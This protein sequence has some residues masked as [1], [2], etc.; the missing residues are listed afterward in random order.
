MFRLAWLSILLVV[1]VSPARGEALTYAQVLQRVVDRDAS[2]QIARMELER[3]RLETPRVESQLGW[4]ANGQAGV[5]RDVNSFGSPVDRADVGAGVE[6]RLES[7]SSLG[8]NLGV[9]REESETVIFPFL[10]NPSTTVKADANYRLPLAQGSDNVGYR[11][12]LETAAASIDAAEAEWGAARNALA[13]QVAESFY[14]AA[15]TY[16]RLRNAEEAIERAERLKR[17]VSQNVRLGVSEEKDR[18]QAEAQL[19]ARLTE[20][21][22]L[23]A[24]WENQR[25]ALNRLMER[26]WSSEWQPFVE[27]QSGANPFDISIVEKEALAASADLRREQAR[28]RVAESTIAR[29]RDATR[30]K[31]DMVF[32]LGNRTQT[33]DLPGGQYANSEPVA[34]L[35]MEYRAALDSRG[36]D[37]ELTQ[38]MIE[39]DIARRRLATSETTLRYAVA[40]L[41][42][43]IEALGAALQQARERKDAEL[44]KLDEATRRH[45]TGRAT[46]SELIQFENDYEAAALAVEQ[47]TIE[48]SRRHR[49]LDRLRG[50]WD[51]IAFDNNGALETKR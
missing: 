49:E 17:F 48:L 14:A 12:G 6:R 32:S 1:A 34:G 35:R 22:T 13:Q 10:P 4:I 30:D 33:G 9:A 5:A 46:T 23:R 27:E 26:E 40:R 8:F 7:G 20:Q 28:V 50:V 41:V 42:S 2:L 39:R 44:R 24:T 31:F 29:R 51:G 38:A 25:I 21:R 37:A 16:A 3:A 18:L 43:E 11:Q 47:Q 19:R 36:T 45:R 15:L